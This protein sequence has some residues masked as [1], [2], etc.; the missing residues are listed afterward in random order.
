MLE[1]DKR[2][3]DFSSSHW[4]KTHTIWLD[5]SL[6]CI[7]ALSIKDANIEELV[8]SKI[9]DY[10]IDSI[11]PKNVYRDFQ[12]AL[13][14][15]NS[16]LENLGWKDKGI[17]WLHACIG[18]Y[19]KKTLYFSTIGKAS[20]YLYNV[21]RDVIEITDKSDHPKVFSHILSGDLADG[22]TIC[23]STSRLLETLS[24][25]DI[26]E[27]M[28]STQDI[29]ASWDILEHMLTR[30]DIS[31][32]MWVVVFRSSW[33]YSNEPSVFWK[34]FEN[35]KYSF[36]RL[37]DNGGVKKALSYF[38]IYKDKL[39]A[40]SQKFQQYVYGAGFVLS[41]IILYFVV[42]WFISFTSNTPDNAELKTQL[43]TA[44]NYVVAAS[45]NMN[46]EDIFTL[47]IDLA[48]DIISDLK[49]QEVFLWDLDKLSDQIWILQK[50]FNGIEPFITDAENTLYSFD[51]LKNITKVVW[52]EGKIYIVHDR[53]ITWPIWAWSETQEYVFD[54]LKK[55][56]RFVD[57]T[58]Y[59]GN[60]IMVTKKWK[61]VNFA[62]NNFFSFQDVSGQDVWENSDIVSSYGNNIY[63]L[64]DSKNQ[65]LMHRKSGGVFTEW[66]AYL[67]DDDVEA[68]GEIFS[69]A[70]DWGIYILKSDGSIVKLFR[71][72]KYRLESLSLNKLPKNYDFSTLSWFKTPYIQSGINL[73][74]VYMLFK[75]KI[76]V[77]KANSTRFQDTKSLEYLGQ[78][79]WK[80]ETIEWFYVE[81]EWE[82]YIST[83][84][85]VH[86]IE[87]NII[88][89]SL[90][91][92]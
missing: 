22:E 27:S 77:F 46:D 24:K 89:D 60:I 86:K 15:I 75:N 11:H 29:H 78:I 49:S 21:N 19:H 83:Q 8:F 51:T 18:I 58:P 20:C 72:P 10:I 32:N 7:I 76:F 62:K 65:I 45:E 68:T 80:D 41:V 84:S 36:L 59:N 42:S 9:V 5:E 73:N 71:S 74:S 53:S 87:Y 90:K 66:T 91:I 33:M 79:E 6:D 14:N 16:F 92:N 47:N 2:I 55:D 34:Y 26:K 57:A 82:I 3:I 30:E 38:Y 61:V 54:D 13:E 69:I 37:L 44:Q 35:A 85:W 48:N 1:I 81:N 43:L 40:R 50:Q 17:K 39:L 12:S 64:A 67:R 25:D 88:D 31:K 52:I 23:I 63:M 28:E 70:I 4:V 56:D